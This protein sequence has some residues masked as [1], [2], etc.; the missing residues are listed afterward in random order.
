M[1][2]LR[3][4]SPFDENGF[5]VTYLIARFDFHSHFR[6]LGQDCVHLRTDSGHAEYPAFVDLTAH[7]EVVVDTIDGIQSVTDAAELPS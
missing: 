2:C 1:F 5:A 7:R 4:I 6:G 3:I